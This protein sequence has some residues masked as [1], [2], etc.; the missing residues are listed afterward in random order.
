MLREAGISHT[1]CWDLSA[2]VKELEIGAGL[3]VVAEEAIR[4]ADVRE[5]A[6]W[7]AEQ[8]S[9]SDFPFVL[10][11]E[12]SAGL[13]RNPMAARLMELLGNTTFVERP[14]HPTTL[15]S[16]VRT[17]S[18][19]RQRQ[20]QSREQIQALAESEATARRA[21]EQLQQLNETLEA[22]VEE[23]TKE[24]AAANRQLFSQIE[25]R[26][27]VESTLHQ[28]QRLEAVGQ[29]TSGVAHDFNNLL[30][31]VLGNIAFVE[32]HLRA[33]GADEGFSSVWLTCAPLLNV[34]PS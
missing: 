34:V 31:V 21:E 30:T 29:L 13:E 11:T 24:L 26:E 9:W 1:I 5:I 3:A 25:E 2:L 28:M 6:R 4:A 15:I 10:L 8:P 7:I 18:R 14:F 20:Y 32:R 33:T 23:R 17:A 16:I 27:R 12:R 22:R 19:G